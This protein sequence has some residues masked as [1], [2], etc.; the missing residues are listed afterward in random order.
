M[1]EYRLALPHEEEDILDFVN[2]VFSQA[3]V[4]RHFDTLIPKVYKHPGYSDFHYVAVEKDRIRGLVAMLPVELKMDEKRS[5]KGG[6][7]GSVAV[8]ERYR[9]E[10]YM[11]NLMNMAIADAKEKG[12]DFL[13]LGGQRQRYNYWD[14]ERCGMN[15]SFYLTGTNVRHAMKNVDESG[16]V[17][18]EITDPKDAQL[19]AIYALAMGSHMICDRPR[20]K[21]LDIMQSYENHLYV[22]ENEAGALLGYLCGRADALVEMEVYDEAMIPPVLKAWM[23]NRSSCNIKAPFYHPEWAKY[24][25]KTAERYG[26]DDSQMFRILNWQRVLEKGLSYRHAHTFLP[27]GSLFVEIENEGRYLLEVGEEVKVT[28]TEEDPDFTF[29]HREAVAFFF[30]PYEWTVTASPL[31]K[32]W[33]PLPLEIRD[34]DKF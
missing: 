14:F 5:L 23:K 32:S 19:D 30:S 20:E 6:Y 12:Y 10:G 18:R 16:I 26:I 3:A 29:T 7:I 2:M 1:A 4:P 25:K 27:K 31:V 13:A 24:L 9:G 33:L 22:A 17:I 21:F 11:K 28:E 8:H 15:R 34:V